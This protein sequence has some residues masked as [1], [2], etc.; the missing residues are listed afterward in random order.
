M[1]SSNLTITGGFPSAAA[2]FV[3]V[4]NGVTDGSVR[5]AK[6]FPL[7]QPVKLTIRHSASGKSNEIVDRHL[8]SITKVVPNGATLATYTC[9]LTIAAPRA[10]ADA[11]DVVG[12]LEYLFNF[13]GMTVDSTERAAMLPITQSLLLSE[14]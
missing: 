2:N 7:S 6:E 5:I 9:N 1:L 12:I 14:S 10:V 13:F 8:V 3:E 11:D 4:T